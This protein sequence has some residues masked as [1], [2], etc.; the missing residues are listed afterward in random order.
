MNRSRKKKG[1]KKITLIKEYLIKNILAIFALVLVIINSV[2]N[3]SQDIGQNTEI[4]FIQ[5]TKVSTLK[6]AAHKNSFDSYINVQHPIT[7]T[8]NSAIPVSIIS[9]VSISDFPKIFISDYISDV[10][11][12]F[13][14]NVFTADDKKNAFPLNIQKGETVSLSVEVRYR[15][16]QRKYDFLQKFFT[17]S[18]QIEFDFLM[19][20]SFLK[21]SANDNFDIDKMIKEKEIKAKENKI[22]LK[23][24]TG[25]KNNFT[26]E[27]TGIGIY[28]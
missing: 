17:T 26:C 6:L 10:Y 19:L 14:E 1:L 16:A 18:K 23:F 3:I 4:L 27:I 9:F 25:R 15:I 12:V 5:S 7:I 13:I 24:I 20:F 21:Y 2:Y 11:P 28:F 22:Q 8:N